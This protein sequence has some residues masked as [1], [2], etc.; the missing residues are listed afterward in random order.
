MK[1]HIITVSYK[2]CTW[3]QI[4][5]A[6]NFAFQSITIRMKTGNY[7][8]SSKQLFCETIISVWEQQ[9]QFPKGINKASLEAF[10][11]TTI[12]FE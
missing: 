2:L 1:R 12:D 8:G 9:L 5:V 3:I 10:L 11:E 4:E 7:L 6:C